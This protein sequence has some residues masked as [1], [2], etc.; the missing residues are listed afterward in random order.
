MLCSAAA[1]P[2]SGGQVVPLE[3]GPEVVAPEAVALKVVAPEVAPLGGG[4]EARRPQLLLHGLFVGQLH[5]LPRRPGRRSSPRV[6]PPSLRPATVSRGWAGGGAGQG[7]TGRGG[8]GR[9][10][11]R[12]P[13]PGRRGRTSSNGWFCTT[14]CAVPPS[15]PEPRAPP[16]PNPSSIA[17]AAPPAPPPPL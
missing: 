8:A 1:P 10:G 11:P 16:N 12:A 14:E 5:L 3:R 9:G 6:S 4:T 17:R 13:G 7:G 2:Q 15:A